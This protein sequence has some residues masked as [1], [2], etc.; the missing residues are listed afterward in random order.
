L[1]LFAHRTIYTLLCDFLIKWIQ[2][3][4]LTFLRSCVV[5]RQCLITNWSCLSNRS[6]DSSWVDSIS[7]IWIYIISDGSICL[8]NTNLSGIDNWCGICGAGSI[9]WNICWIIWITNI[10]TDWR[11]N[12][13]SISWIYYC[14][15]CCYIGHINCSIRCTRSS[16]ICLVGN[17]I[18]CLINSWIRSRVNISRICS[19]SRLKMNNWCMTGFTI[20]TW[21]GILVIYLTCGAGNTSLLIFII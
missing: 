6:I 18:D 9:Y 13:D 19:I 1:R 4:C 15:Y 14:G 11:I 2:R 8:R 16:D 3:A 20:N 21:A 10:L 7:I 17:G 12:R 5:N